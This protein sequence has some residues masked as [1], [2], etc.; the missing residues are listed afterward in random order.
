MRKDGSRFSYAHEYAHALLDR[1][2]NITISSTDNS[3]EMVE[4]RAKR[5][6]RRLSY[7]ERGN[8]CFPAEPRQGPAEPPGPCH[9]RCRHRRPHRSRAASACSLAK[10]HLQ[11]QRDAR[12][13]LG[14]SYQAAL[15]RLK[16]LRYISDRECG[17]LLE[18]EAFGRKYLK[19]LAWVCRER[20]K[21]R[22]WD[23]ELRSEIAHL[24]IEAYRREEISRGRVL[25]LS[26]TLRI[27]G[28]T[29]LTLPKRLAANDTGRGRTPAGDHRH[30]CVRPHQFLRID[31]ADLLRGHSHTFPSHRPCRRENHGPLSRSA[32][33]LRRGSRLL[34]ALSR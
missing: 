27:A 19:R 22:Y 13:P 26:K 31:R 12:I 14:V 9:L 8:P 4:K 33:T 29:P 1:N 16:S 21:Q 7:A 6:R 10:D 2:G 24:A 15:Y 30:R 11:R 34:P 3:S 5:V 18:Q 20:E 28:D 25:E 17:D 23:R 32:T